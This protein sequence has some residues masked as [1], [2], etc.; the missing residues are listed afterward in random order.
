MIAVTGACGFLGCNIV[1]ALLQRG[2]H[3]LAIDRSPDWPPDA[4]EHFSSLPGLL[5]TA[6]ADVR[7]PAAL[8]HA[9]A[10]EGGALDALVHAAA[11]TPG[12]EREARDAALIAEVNTLGTLRTLEAARERGVGRVVVTSSASVYGA[13]GDGAAGTHLDEGRDAPRPNTIYGISKFAAEGVA[14]RVAAL[15]GLELVVV[16]IGGAFGPWEHDSGW[17]DTLSGPMLATRALLAGHEVLVDPGGHHDWVYAP[18]V[19]GAVLALLAAT[20][21]PASLVHVSGGER[22]TLTDWVTALSAALERRGRP[23]APS[24]SPVR[25]P[26]LESPRTGLSIERLRAL[27]TPRFALAE[28]VEDYLDWLERRS[29]AWFASW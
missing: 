1:E 24:G 19:A 8:R 12:P 29:P 14:L 3:V 23:Y 17:R 22:W 21:P 28:A 27:Y 25:F 10:H 5:D 11:V 4:L 16:R 2:H 13:A 18:D 20:R 26:A 6:V 7:D 15:W 9:L